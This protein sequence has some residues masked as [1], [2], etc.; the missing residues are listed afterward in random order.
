[1]DAFCRCRRVSRHIKRYA[2]N[3][4]F[5]RTYTALKIGY[6]RNH[7]VLFDIADLNSF[8]KQGKVY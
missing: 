4:S 6:D 7:T 1:M 3:L 5:A 8:V 2:Q